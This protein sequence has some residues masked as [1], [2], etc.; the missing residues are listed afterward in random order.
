MLSGVL[1]FSRVKEKWQLKYFLR[2]PRRSK[3]YKKK[4]IKILS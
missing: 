1:G 3:R 2:L 4:I